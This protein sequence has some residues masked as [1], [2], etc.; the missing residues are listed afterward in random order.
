MNEYLEWSARF[1][2]PLGEFMEMAKGDKGAEWHLSDLLPKK[3]TVPAKGLRGWFGGKETKM[4]NPPAPEM[5]TVR[6][7]RDH[8]GI[9]CAHAWA[10]S[11][12]LS[13]CP[14]GQTLQKLCQKANV[15]VKHDLP[16]VVV[17]FTPSWV[18][19]ECGCQCCGNQTGGSCEPR[20]RW[21]VVEELEKI[22]KDLNT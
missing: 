9:T 5:V 17:V 13:F 22:L 16:D 18:H 19:L 10:T 14:S 8:N 2:L 4:V 21:E 15:P 11:V 20:F 7:T 1:K 3:T 6:F 12:S